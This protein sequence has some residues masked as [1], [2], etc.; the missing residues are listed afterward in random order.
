MGKKTSLIAFSLLVGVLSPWHGAASECDLV[1]SNLH[2][3]DGSESN[4]FVESEWVNPEETKRIF[5]DSSKCCCHDYSIPLALTF[6]AKHTEGHGVGYRE[7]Y[8][9]LG[10]LLGTGWLGNVQSFIDV[11]AHCFNNGKMAA[12]GGFGFRYYNA[13]KMMMVGLN[14]YYDYRHSEID[15][16]QV[17]LGLEVGGCGFDLRVNGY[18]PVGR[19][20]HVENR[21]LAFSSDRALR[22][23]HIQEALWGFDGEIETSLHRW[24]PCISRCWD[25]YIAGGTYYYRSNHG[26]N[27]RGGKVRC[28]VVYSDCLTLEV[29]TTFDNVYHTITQ[30]TI[31]LS[32]TFGGYYTSCCSQCPRS[33]YPDFSVQPVQRDEIIVLRDHCA[34]TDRTCKCL[35]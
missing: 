20:K 34:L 27:I 15:Y 1:E 12:N 14:A 6:F 19:K 26:H 13:N 16:Q 17:G 32:C 3:S 21:G 9:T 28:G 22:H 31:G 30:G 11:R 23:H 29:K 4:Y 5:P 18:C 35:R 25:P 33:C 2:Y 24:D 7:G 8:S 10:F